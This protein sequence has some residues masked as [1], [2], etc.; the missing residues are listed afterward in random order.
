MKYIIGVD[1]GGTFTDCAVFD[2]SLR[3]ILTAKAETTPDNPAEGFFN[4]LQKA[5]ADLVLAVDSLLAQTRILVNASTTGTNAIVTKRG[6]TVG[7][8]TTAGHGQSLYI[9]NGGGRTKG[10][11]V[12]ELLYMAGTD[13]PRPLVPRD[14]IEEIIERV[15]CKG[16]VVVKLNEARAEQSIRRLLSKGI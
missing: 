4:S 12:D 2:T 16:D 8:L 6:A 3:A 9:M 5:A 1:I 7:L 13:K 11:T 14:R 15:D 10:L